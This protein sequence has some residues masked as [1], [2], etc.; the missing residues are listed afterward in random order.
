MN[1]KTYLNEK[2]K[3]NKVAEKAKRLTATALVAGTILTG[4]GL[5]ACEQKLNMSNEE[6]AS[7]I[8]NILQEQREDFELG[9]IAFSYFDNKYFLLLTNEDVNDFIGYEISKSQFDKMIKLAE[10]IKNEGIEFNEDHTSVLIKDEVLHNE[11]LIEIN[12][13][14]YKIV[15]NESQVDLSKYSQFE[16]SNSNSDDSN[17]RGQKNDREYIESGIKDNIYYNDLEG[18]YANFRADYILVIPQKELIIE[19]NGNTI[20]LG[21]RNCFEF[22]DFVSKDGDDIPDTKIIVTFMADKDFDMNGFISLLETKIDND[23][24]KKNKNGYFLLNTSIYD[25]ENMTNVNAYLRKIAIGYGE[26][27]PEFSFEE[28]IQQEETENFVK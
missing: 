10:N 7:G 26:F 17:S 12:E 20:N 27:M 24:I 25:D 3:N 4:A 13:F 18:K 11:N 8:V 21:K 9:D 22:I 19:K 6:L 16:T 2:L 1:I 5:T 23:I 15:S 14:I 28:P